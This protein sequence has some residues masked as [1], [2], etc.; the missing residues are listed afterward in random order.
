MATKKA[1]TG[2][3]GSRTAKRTGT[4]RTHTT[5]RIDTDT[6]GRLMRISEESGK[7]LGQ[8]ISEAAAELEQRRFISQLRADYR[9]MRE[10]PEEWESYVTERD[11]W[12]LGVPRLREDQP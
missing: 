12:L 8:V 5:V 9:R 3:S 10:N 7:P 6:H 1:A 4:I 11:Q 2:G